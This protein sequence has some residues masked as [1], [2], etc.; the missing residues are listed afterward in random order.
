[1]SDDIFALLSVFCPMHV[2]VGA[3]GQIT[4]CGASVEKLFAPTRLVGQQFDAAFHLIRP[5]GSQG[6]AGLR[7]AQGGGLQL[8]LRQ[9]RRTRLRGVAVAFGPGVIVNLGFGLSILDAVRDYTLS[10]AD[11]ARTDIAIELLYLVEAKSAAMAASRRLNLRLQGARLAAEE[12]A[13]TD[14]LTGL[15]N[16]RA[17]EWV[18]ERLVQA[19]APFAVMQ[20][21]LDHFKPVNDG[22]GHAAGDALLAHVA[23]VLGQETRQ[24]DL[25]ARVGGD[26][27][28]L[29]FAGIAERARL[30]QIAERIQRRLAQP[31]YWGDVA[32]KISASIGITI[33]G[34]DAR[35]APVLL[36][37]A[38][39]ALYAAK[40]A[41]RAQHAFHLAPPAQ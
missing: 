41:G 37:E 33:A 25:A 5:R 13:I 40:H 31:F 7:A 20:V 10:A 17:M 4:H 8:E 11:F 23:Q 38:D 39:A 6:L 26:E 3:Q 1:M 15:A 36:A 14:S 9:P 28:V 12:A 21:D 2:A 35:P 29:L 34:G 30:S 22:L 24:D 16:R 18:L 27:F 32:C 19:R